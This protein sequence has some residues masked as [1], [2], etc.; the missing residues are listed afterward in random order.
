[1]KFYTTTITPEFF[2]THLKNESPKEITWKD[3]MECYVIDII[4][5]AVGEGEMW[6]LDTNGDFYPIVLYTKTNSIRTEHDPETFM[7]L[8]S[9]SNRKD[10]CDYLKLCIPVNYYCKTTQAYKDLEEYI[11]VMKQILN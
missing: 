4:I 6:I 1:M 9:P 2:N 10:L 8:L 7:Q 3:R 11:K 5:P